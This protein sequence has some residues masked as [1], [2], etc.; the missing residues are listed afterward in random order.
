[1]TALDDSSVNREKT[2]PLLL[3]MFCSTKKHNNVLEYSRGR[4]PMNELQVYTWFDATLRELAS[5]VKQ[6]NPESRRKGTLFDFALVFPDHRSPVYR[7]RELGTVCSG[8]PSDTDRIMLKDVQFTIGDMI[9]VAITPPLTDA[10]I[11]CSKS[12]SLLPL[13]SSHRLLKQNPIIRGRRPDEK[14][15]EHSSDKN[16][17]PELEPSKYSRHVNSVNPTSQG[18]EKSEPGKE[19][20]SDKKS[21]DKS[22]DGRYSYK[23]NGRRVVPY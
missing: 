20:R 19:T 22:S 7:M 4:T 10:Y 11:P 3:R 1:M 6:V 5:L 17:N 23:I 18:R 15:R 16:N 9:D 13:D 14:Y 8:S 21:Y 2:C 12:D